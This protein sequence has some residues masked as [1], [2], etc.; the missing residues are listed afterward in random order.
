MSLEL[1][2]GGVV[3]HLRVAVGGAHLDEGFL[4]TP[5][6][7][8][9]GHCTDDHLGDSVENTAFPV[10]VVTAHLFL[11]LGVGLKSALFNASQVSV[12]DVLIVFNELSKN[13]LTSSVKVLSELSDTHNVSALEVDSPDEDGIFDVLNLLS[14]ILGVLF[15]TV[16]DFL[17]VLDTLLALA[18]EFWNGEREPVVV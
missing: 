15:N 6:S 17:E 7:L 12:T 16:L 1:I 14:D 2:D 9:S 4:A 5:E 18:D 11:V 8:V 13:L 10:V 3:R